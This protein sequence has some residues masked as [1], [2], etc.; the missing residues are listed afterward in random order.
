MSSSKDVKIGFNNLKQIIAEG[1]H[2]NPL[3]P[4]GTSNETM[5]QEPGLPFSKSSIPTRRRS[6]KRRNTKTRI[7][8]KP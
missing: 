7:D 4:R 8:Q 2:R 6:N 5:S 3:V 1:V